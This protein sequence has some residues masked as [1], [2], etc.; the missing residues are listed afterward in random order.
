MS[1]STRKMWFVC[2]VLG[3]RLVLAETAAA[4]DAAKEQC[5]DAHSRG[6]DAKQQGKIT[7]ARKLFLACAQASCP[8]LVQSDCA[9]FAD[10]I[11]RVQ[12]SLSFAARDERGN[13]LPD[14]AVYIDGGL[15]LTRIDGGTAHDVD[16]GRHEVRFVNGGREQ[17][18]TLV[19]QSG[20][21][22]RAVVGTF[23]SSYDEDVENT[24]VA[25]TS[26][27]PEV[28]HALGSRVLIGAG[29]S[30]LA[31]GV[32][33]G[34]VGLTKV[35]DNCSL[36]S[37]EC[38]APPQDDAFDRAEKAVRMSNIGWSVGGVGLATVAAG[39][40]WYVKSAS[41]PSDRG[42][43]VVPFATPKSAG[44]TVRTSL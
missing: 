38:A 14:T 10:E 19:V 29:L 13:D 2:F 41:T 23:P 35:P 31:G 34:I 16:P 27:A 26:E 28:T 36:S 15:V 17:T 40:I 6:Q 1:V 42:P 43:E 21:K 30:F 33:L 25:S 32:A 8:S 18:V 7:L 22:G 44:L 12:P 9:R 24:H 4:D 11:E 20:E 39:L 37:H 5:L 3:A